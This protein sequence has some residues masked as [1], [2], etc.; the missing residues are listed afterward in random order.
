MTVAEQL[1]WQTREMQHHL[2]RPFAWI[3][4]CLR[5]TSFTAEKHMRKSRQSPSTFKVHFP[6][7][8]PPTRNASLGE[9]Q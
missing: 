8:R 5:L 1:P 2:A 3:H 7:A 4:V 6:A 9:V